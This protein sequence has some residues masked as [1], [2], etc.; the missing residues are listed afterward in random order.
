M[1]TADVEKER[2]RRGSGKSADGS[3]KPA[4]VA[5]TPKPSTPKSAPVQSRVRNKPRL[6]IILLGIALIIVSGLTAA[7]IYTSTGRTKLVYSAASDIARGDV[8][9]LGSLQVVEIP[10]TNEIPSFERADTDDVE[11]KTAQVDIPAGTLLSPANVSEGAGIDTGM[12]IVGLSLTS[13]Q[14]PPFPLVSGD[15][16]RLV[17][18]PVSQGEPPTKAPVTES[19]EIVSVRTDDVAGTTIVA[20]TVPSERAA[21]LAARAA[22][23][24]VALILD[25][26]DAAGAAVDDETDG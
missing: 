16:V 26:L 5:K 23:G 22:T 19:A 25:P 18:T 8:I 14:L 4:K 9:E 15:K 10:D 17:D 21:L 11:G 2:P 12:S 3:A 24:R 20:V 13:A 1:T 7:Y 6:P